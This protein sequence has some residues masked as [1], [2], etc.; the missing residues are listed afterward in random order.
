MFKHVLKLKHQPFK[1]TQL[2]ETL[3]FQKSTF[4]EMIEHRSKF[5]TVESLGSPN[6][7]VNAFWPPEV[8]KHGVRTPI[9]P[10]GPIKVRLVT[11]EP[12]QGSIGCA[13]AAFVIF[14]LHFI[15]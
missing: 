7:S 12:D 15:L 4:P 14:F 6:P 3:E 5:Q 1:V 11:L 13:G 2:F 10:P 8:D 9:L